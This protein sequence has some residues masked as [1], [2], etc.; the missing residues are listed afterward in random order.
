[1]RVVLARLQRGPRQRIVGR[2]RAG[3]YDEGDVRIGEQGGRLRM[4]GDAAEVGAYLVRIAAGDGGDGET[5][6]RA[7]Q[8]RVEDLAG[9]AIADESNVDRVSGHCVP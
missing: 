6:G 4:D 5:R 2:V 3:Q 9:E 1:V 8:R 7:Q